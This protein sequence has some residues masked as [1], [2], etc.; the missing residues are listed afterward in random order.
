MGETVYIGLAVT[1][2]DAT[3]TAEARVSH[4]TATGDTSPPGPFTESQDIPSQLP[5]RK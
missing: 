1:S 5:P 2:H 3:K 4:L